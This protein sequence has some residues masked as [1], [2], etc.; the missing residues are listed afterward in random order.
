MDSLRLHIKIVNIVN[1]LHLN[2]RASGCEDNV[3]DDD[4]VVRC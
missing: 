2:A 3:D 4:G 1:T